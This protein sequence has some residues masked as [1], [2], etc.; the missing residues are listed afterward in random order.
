MQA[1]EDFLEPLRRLHAQIRDAVVESCEKTAVEE[2]AAV[3]AEEAEDTIYAV[4]RV[5][6]EVLVDFF[7]REIAP[8]APLVLI[9]EGVEGGKLVLPAG[10]READALWRVIVDPIDGTR[11]LMYQKRSAWI[12]TGVAPNQGPRTA[13]SDIGLA[14]QTEIPLVKQHLSD[15]AWALRGQGVRAERWDR[16]RQRA[17][18]LPLRPSTAKG[19]EHGF[20][21]VCRFFPGERKLLGQIDDALMR[22]VL[23]KPQPGKAQCFEDQYISTGGQLYEMMAGHDR[24]VVDIRPLLT[25]L[26]QEKNEP[27]LLCS[28]PY[29]LCTALIAQE[30]GIVL[31]NAD[32]G[33]LDAPLDV[34]TDVSLLA[35]ANKD[36][37]Q[38][39]EPHL[40]ALLKNLL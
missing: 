33:P 6:E 14:L 19:L 22:R 7:A 11:G 23:G 26:R 15:Q 2:M 38:S 39:I 32:G 36:L 13:L 3:A 37:H 27:P 9:A 20:A 1:I 8:K 17:T 21:T 25:P 29:D 35:Y 18:P 40:S 5:S 16:V 34:D 4:D 10:T 24:L 28:H 12:L 31:T 30:M